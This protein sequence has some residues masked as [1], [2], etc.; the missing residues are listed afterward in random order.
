VCQQR[1]G[2]TL[3]QGDTAGDSPHELKRGHRSGESTT[4]LSVC[5]TLRRGAGRSEPL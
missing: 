3:L 4:R 1:G 5:Q 2:S